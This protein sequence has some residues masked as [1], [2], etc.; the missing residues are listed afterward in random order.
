MDRFAVITRR[1]ALRKFGKVG[2]AATAAAGLMEV[3]GRPAVASAAGSCGET[4]PYYVLGPGSCK[5]KCPSGYWCFEMNYPQT[6][7]TGQNYCCKSNPPCTTAGCYIQC[8]C[9]RP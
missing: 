1:A 6:G 9:S 5:I 4:N 3:A 8:S 7:Y 2:L